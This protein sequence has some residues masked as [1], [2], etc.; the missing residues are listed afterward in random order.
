MRKLNAALVIFSATLVSAPVSATLVLDI[1]GGSTA[2][3]SRDFTLGWRF[4]VNSAITING[5]GI[6]DENSDG[7]IPP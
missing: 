3:D 6:W 5:L 4:Q 7:L 2:T 1:T